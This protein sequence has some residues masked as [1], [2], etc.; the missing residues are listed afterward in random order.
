MTDPAARAL[1]KPELAAAYQPRGV[2]QLPPALLAM[3]TV[4]QAC[5]QVGDAE[6]VVTAQVDQRWQLVLGLARAM[7]R[8]RAPRFVWRSGRIGTRPARL[9]TFN[10]S[11]PRAV[12]HRMACEARPTR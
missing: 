9:I 6:A 1:L 4:L 11:G 12:T 8:R 5:D 10:G 2:A 7:R 3:V